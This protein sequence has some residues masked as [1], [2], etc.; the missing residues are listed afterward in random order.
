MTTK[1]KGFTL[2]ELLIVVAIITILASAAIVAINPGKHF[3]QTRNATRWSHMNSVANG[4]Y[5]YIID[6]GGSYP[7]C[8][9]DVGG[10]PIVYNEAG[11]SPWLLVDITTCIQLIPEY[12]SEFPSDPQE[13]GDVPETIY[14]A[15]GFHDDGLSRIIIRSTAQEAIDESVLVIQ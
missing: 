5:S 2:I 3:K 11:G 9:Y 7:D 13:T 14:Y 4:V 10:N 15:I 8:F 1:R 12:I 6:Q